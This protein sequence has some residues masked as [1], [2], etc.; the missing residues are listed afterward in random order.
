MK[1]LATLF[2]LVWLIPVF[3]GALA[4]IIAKDYSQ[5]AAWFLFALLIWVVADRLG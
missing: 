1:I 5:A 4:L 3:I 2:F